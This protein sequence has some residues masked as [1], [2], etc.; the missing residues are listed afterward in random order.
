MESS[1]RF[2][3]IDLTASQIISLIKTRGLLPGDRLPTEQEM[4]TELNVGRGTLR[5]AVRQ[6][7][8]RNILIVRQGSGT[9]VSNQTG[10]PEDPLGLTFIEKGPKLAMDLVEFRLMVEPALAASAA[11]RITKPQKI[12]L[13]RRY[14]VL[15][16]KLSSQDSYVDADAQFHCYIAECS[17][18]SVLQNL[19][20]TISTSVH[21]FIKESDDGFRSRSSDEHLRI[22]NAIC[23]NDPA[24]AK[25]AMVTHLSIIRDYFA[26]PK[27]PLK[28]VW[29]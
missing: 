19:M 17:G 15:A 7:V 22:L 16:S 20:S 4:A 23:R 26:Q 13:A 1:N 21:V 18:N 25:Y 3:L 14:Q 2:T 28:L 11:L 6:L 12:E 9:Y 27:E 10:V 5:E 29:N 8:A 24:G